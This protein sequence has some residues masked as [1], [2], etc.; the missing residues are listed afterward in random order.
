[1]SFRFFPSSF[2]PHLKPVTISLLSKPMGN[3]HGAPPPRRGHRNGVVPPK[4]PPLDT[5]T[6]RPKGPRRPTSPD[7]ESAESEGSGSPVEH[8]QQQQRKKVLKAQGNT[9]AKLLTSF[10]P[11]R[12]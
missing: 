10:K 8:Q 11:R 5:I 12:D 1:M 3:I 4:P 2:V 7:P 9:L 6:E